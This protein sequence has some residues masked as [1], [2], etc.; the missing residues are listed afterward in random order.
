MFL[1]IRSRLGACDVSFIMEF[2]FTLLFV[3][4]YSTM[5]GLD[6]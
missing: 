4:M 3:N 5:A 2:G 6:P 1:L